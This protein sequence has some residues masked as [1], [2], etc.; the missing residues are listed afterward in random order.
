M[1]SIFEKKFSSSADNLPEIEQ[2]IIEIVSDIEDLKEETKNNIEMAV[3]EAAA[4]SILHG[5]KNDNSKSVLINIEISPSLLILKFKDQGAGFKPE[6]VPDPTLPENILKGSG[7]GLHIMKS[8]A[9]NVDYNF[10][11]DGTQLVLSFNI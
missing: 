5:N 10:F 1:Q 7:R 2:F 11:E 9:D 4:N 6:D 3:A 8:L